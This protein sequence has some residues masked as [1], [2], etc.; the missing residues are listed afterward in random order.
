MRAKFTRMPVNFIIALALLAAA[1]PPNRA[2]VPMHVVNNHVFV[3]VSL[4]GVGPFR[5]IVD[6]GA[7]NLVDPAVARRIGARVHGHLRLVGVGGALESGALTTVST[8]R[9]GN[10][11][12]AD[13][14]FVV[15]RTRATFSAAEGP[16]VDGLIGR[17]IIASGVT[18]FDY[19]RQTVTFDAGDDD[20]VRGDT[21][22][23]PLSTFGGLPQVPCKVAGVSGSCTVDTGSRLAVSVLGPFARR[24][25]E[26]V[27]ESLSATGVNG[28]GIGGPAYGQLGLLKSLSFGSITVFNVI[29]DFSVQRRGV[30]ADATTAAN[31][32]GGVW[33]RFTLAFDFP[34]HR[35]GLRPND[36]FDEPRAV[37]RSGLFVIARDNAVTI[38]DVRPQTPAAR[39]GLA[40][41]DVIVAVNGR[42]LTS[43]L[44]PALRGILEGEPDTSV[45]LQIARG[46]QPSR[47]VTLRLGNYL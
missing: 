3:D 9:I 7:G 40:P 43:E 35:I 20:V 37:D 11:R 26:V 27:P 12:F 41:G 39:V 23:L 10:A 5:F 30:F 31:V 25:P 36:D 32:G 24:H 22:V 14:R 45:D 46:A 6:S 44:L 29:A 1:P 34:H 19:A 28:Y 15:A 47:H 42:R 38:L 18:V 13:Q 8:I 17:G 33:R 4:N 2:A 16:A 21:T